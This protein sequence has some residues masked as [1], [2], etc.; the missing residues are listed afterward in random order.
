MIWRPNFTLNDEHGIKVSA[1]DD[2]TQWKRA[3]EAEK[4]S[5][6]SLFQVAPGFEIELVHS[7]TTDEGSWVS[8]A[9]DPK[10]R[11]VI[12]RED[13]G[14]LRI[15]LAS[16]GS[17]I[18]RIETINDSLQECRGLLFAFDSLYVNA[19]NSK[20]FLSAA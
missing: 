12:A 10:G 5:D 15:T 1:Y 18:H 4:G 14:L 20:G 2:Y 6:P 11:L 8:L 17:Q 9:V 16:G 3:L 7:A 19:N 13:Q